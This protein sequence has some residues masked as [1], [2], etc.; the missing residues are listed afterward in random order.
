[1]IKE[2]EDRCFSY[3]RRDGVREFLRRLI[4]G[5]K[6]EEMFVQFGRSGFKMFEIEQKNEKNKKP[7]FRFFQ[8]IQ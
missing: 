7:K 1:M 5:E 8:A 3:E 2:L 4:N 6:K